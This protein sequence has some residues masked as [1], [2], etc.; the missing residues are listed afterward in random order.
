MSGKLSKCLYVY[1]Y[2]VIRPLITPSAL[3]ECLFM[4]HSFQNNCSTECHWTHVTQKSIEVLLYNKCHKINL[5]GPFGHFLFHVILT[6]S[7]LRAWTFET[8]SLPKDSLRAPDQ[9]NCK[10]FSIYKSKLL[11]CLLGISPA[12]QNP[13]GGNYYYNYYHHHIII[14]ITKTN[15]L[16]KLSNWNPEKI[17]SARIATRAC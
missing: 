17:T 1:N 10:Y 5:S 7:Y 14:I 11:R 9:A 13:C 3:N 8:S 4:V 2:T 15:K 6:I 12:G 16:F